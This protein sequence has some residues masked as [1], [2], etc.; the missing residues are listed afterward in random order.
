MRDD[1]DFV[2]AAP[3]FLVSHATN[4]LPYPAFP[5]LAFPSFAAVLVP[6]GIPF[7]P[8]WAGPLLPAGIP[9]APARGP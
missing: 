4:V 1:P 2:L 9:I 8:G 6:G 7:P 5:V 3:A